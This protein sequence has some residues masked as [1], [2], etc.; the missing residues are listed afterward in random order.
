MEAFFTRKI[1]FLVLVDEILMLF[2]HSPFNSNVAGIS[3]HA[4][5]VTH[6]LLRVMLEQTH[7]DECCV[8]L[9]GDP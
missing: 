2:E 9:E 8:W 3:N 1:I 7:G 4:C 5:V 6:L